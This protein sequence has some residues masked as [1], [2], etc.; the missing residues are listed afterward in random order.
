[1]NFLYTYIQPKLYPEATLP[2]TSLWPCMFIPPWAGKAVRTLRAVVTADGPHWEPSSYMAAPTLATTWQSNSKQRSSGVISK[3]ACYR[4][5]ADSTARRQ[6]AQHKEEGLNTCA[7]LSLFGSVCL[8]Y[9]IL[10]EG[11]FLKPWDLSFF[12]EGN[13]PKTQC[14]FLLAT[15]VRP[16]M[17]T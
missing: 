15:W 3:S 2:L 13:V 5:D 11:I 4:V 10:R 14:N 8:L 6:H 9:I 17:S 7:K 16:E 12:S 1:M